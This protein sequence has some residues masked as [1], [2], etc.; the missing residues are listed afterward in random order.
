MY[1]DSELTDRIICSAYNVH[2]LLGGGFLEKVYENALFLELGEAG[3]NV[4]Q[5]VPIHV[6]YKGQIVGE[7]F[8]DLLV[9]KRIILE[10]KAVE[11]LSPLHEIQLRNYLKGS[12][13]ELGLL[14]NFGKSVE[15]KRK[16][17]K[18]G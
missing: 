17:Q 2:N 3:L 10:L 7:Y 1:Q 9:E 15:I 14:I 8:A 12:R 5:Q 16:Y 6:R 4:E 13:I 18:N 11:T